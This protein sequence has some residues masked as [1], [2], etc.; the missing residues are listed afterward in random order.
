MSI[1]WEELTEEQQQ[2]YMKMHSNHQASLSEMDKETI[3]LAD[4]IRTAEAKQDVLQSLQDWPEFR[5]LWRS[6]CLK[7]DGTF[8]E[9]WSVTFVKD[10]EY[11]DMHYQ[12]TP[13]QAL[14]VARRLFEGS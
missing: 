4:K 12:P 8:D 2:G 7:E 1:K 6:H 9:G 13:H 5:G 11:C 10:G 3:E 14:E